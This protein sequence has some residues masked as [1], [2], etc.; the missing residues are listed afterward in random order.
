LTAHAQYCA[1][2]YTG[3]TPF[4]CTSFCVHLDR[5]D[6]SEERIASIIR[7]ERINELGKTLAVTVTAYILPSSQILVALM[8]EAMRFSEASVLTGAARRHILLC[9]HSLHHIL[10]VANESLCIT[11]AVVAVSLKPLIECLR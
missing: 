6:V 1:R 2:G 4:S 5:T 11:S 9:R 7:V 3:P 10:Q 8:M